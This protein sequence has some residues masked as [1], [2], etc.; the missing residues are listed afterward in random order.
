ML[1]PKRSVLIR[2]DIEVNIKEKNRV[3]MRLNLEDIDINIWNGV[4]A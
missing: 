1:T 4:G 2:R 3:G